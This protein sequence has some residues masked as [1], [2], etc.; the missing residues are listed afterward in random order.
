V[1]IPEGTIQARERELLDPM[2]PQQREAV[3]QTDG[4]LLIVAGAGSGKTR[5]I[6]HRIAYLIDVR[7]VRPERVLAVT[8]TNKAAQEMRERIDALL[9]PASKR[10]GSPLVSTFHSLCVRIL[11]RDA[12]RLNEGYTRNFTIYDSDDTSRLLKS[13]LAD[14]HIDEKM[15]PVRGVHSA[16]SSAKNRGITPESYEAR[17]GGGTG[18]GVEQRRQAIAAI[19]K[20]YEQRKTAANALDFDDLLLKTVV[21][22][23][24]DEE[25]REYYN[26]RFRYIMVDEYQDTNQPQFSLVRLLTQKTQNVCV[27]GDEDQGIYS[28][29]GA[30]IGN[31]LSFEEQY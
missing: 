14:L 26:D 8:F 13:C 3:M 17:A 10:L 31:I 21:L 25:T 7:G 9:T 2:N 20:L 30:D 28:W 24:R 27:V 6:T 11:R 15:V 22:L 1:S 12:E 4:P 18:P 29:R 23:R 5:V 16:I 19:F